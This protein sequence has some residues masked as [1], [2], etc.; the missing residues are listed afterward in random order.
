MLKNLQNALTR[1]Y[2]LEKE[3]SGINKP[4]QIK[5][6]EFKKVLKSEVDNIAAS[7]K[8]VSGLQNF[9]QKPPPSLQEVIKSAATKYDLP[10]SLIQAVIKAESNGN[11]YAKS[12]KG[13]LGLMQLMPQ[14]AKMLQVKNPFNIKENI[15]GGSK[16]L[17]N[18]LTLFDNDLPK[19]LAAYNAGPNRVLQEGK[20]PD[21]AETKTYI[22]RVL[23]Y[24]KA[25][26]QRGA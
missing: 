16:Y 25:Y 15:E 1:I 11:V 18:M 4:I 10:S 9:S 6:P 14:T 20:I 21:I 12:P 3:L 23:K 2:H 26:Q 7:A 24:F 19:A 13:A 17:K 8:Q 5:K 22:Q